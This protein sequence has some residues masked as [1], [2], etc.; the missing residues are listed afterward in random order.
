M[1][2]EWLVVDAE[3]NKM[4]QISLSGGKRNGLMITFLPNG[5]TYH[6][7]SYDNGV[8]VGDVL[9]ADSKTGELKRIATYIDGRRIVTSVREITGARD[10]QVHTNEVY[11]APDPFT[12][13]VATAAGFTPRLLHRLSAASPAGVGPLASGGWG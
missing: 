13:A 6:Q 7:A 9:E 1:D 4:M 12:P 3:N 5:K 8:P 2:G 11:T 10:G